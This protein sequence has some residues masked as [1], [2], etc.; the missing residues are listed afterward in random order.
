MEEIP[1]NTTNIDQLELD[2]E[3]DMLLDEMDEYPEEAVSP[4]PI[5]DV[6]NNI[7]SVEEEEEE[8]EDI[9]KK[10]NPT[11]NLFGKKIDVDTTIVSSLVI[12]VWIIIWNTTGLF[13]VIKKGDKIFISIFILFILYVITNT[14]TAGHSSGG[15][16]Y[17]LNILL[18]VEQ[19]ISILFG[20]I[21]LFSLFNNKINIDKNCSR[22]INKLVMSIVVILSTSSLWVNVITNGRAF[23]A[24][25]KFKQG[26]YNASLTLFIIVGMIYVRGTSCNGGLEMI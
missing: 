6:S 11:W 24:I 26:I 22:V 13:N 12:L 4:S 1:P 14:Y 15:V 20:T 3:L 21:V 10:Q 16:V 8:E 9:G 19:M 7:G 17:E 2:E 23:R 25:R 18:T 5:T